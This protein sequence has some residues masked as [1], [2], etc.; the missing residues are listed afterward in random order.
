MMIYV[1][2][3]GRSG[4]DNKMCEMEDWTNYVEGMNLLSEGIY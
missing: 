4:L 3:K 1:R 2:L